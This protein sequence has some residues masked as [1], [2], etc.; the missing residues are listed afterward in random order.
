MPT[1]DRVPVST[2]GMQRSTHSLF[3]ICVSVTSSS[4]C[5]LS[6]RTCN[7]LAADP[8]TPA[9]SFSELRAAQTHKPYRSKSAE[10]TDPDVYPLERFSQRAPIQRNH[11]PSSSQEPAPTLSLNTAIREYIRGTTNPGGAPP[12]IYQPEIPSSD[13]ISVAADGTEQEVPVNHIRGAWASKQKYLSDHYALLREDGVAPLRNVVSEL[14]AKP[15]TLEQDSAE[16][17]QIYEKVS[18]GFESVYTLS[19]RFRRRSSS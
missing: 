17:S 19:L 11:H 2:G 18:V 4:S 16:Q 3:S 12:F 15:D 7:H 6:L 9:A 1:A 14:Q 5:S 8:S 13:E 10:T